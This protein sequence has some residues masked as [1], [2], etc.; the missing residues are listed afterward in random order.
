MPY[1]PLLRNRLLLGTVA[2][3][4]PGADT[5][6]LATLTPQE[7]IAQRRPKSSECDIVVVVFW[8]RPPK[9]FEVLLLPN[10]PVAVLCID[11]GLELDLGDRTPGDIA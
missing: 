4:K 5:P 3:D 2:W 10:V 1:D 6:M 11:E 8:R 7:A 9:P